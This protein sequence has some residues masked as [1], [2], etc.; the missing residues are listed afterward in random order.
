MSLTMEVVAVP[1][2]AELDLDRVGGRTMP[3]ELREQQSRMLQLCSETPVV[4]PAS[5]VTTPSNANVQFNAAAF[6]ETS[7]VPTTTLD[8]SRPLSPHNSLCFP[9][10]STSIHH[11]AYD[12][13]STPS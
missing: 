2:D 8:N 9:S 11:R 3:A 12:G 10:A 5:I 4:D 13:H 6:H 7:K 1:R